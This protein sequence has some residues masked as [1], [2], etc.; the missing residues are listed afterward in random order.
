MKCRGFRPHNLAK[1][2]FHE[3]DSR[4]AFPGLNNAIMPAHH[5]LSDDLL[6]TCN[7][8]FARGVS[9]SHALAK[10][11]RVGVPALALAT[12]F[13]LASPAA[14]DEE[15]VRP[16]AALTLVD[17][18][19][20]PL[21]SIDAARRYADLEGAGFVAWHP[22][23]RAMLVT[24]RSGDTHQLHLLTAPEAVPR[25]LTDFADPVRVAQFEPREGRYIV[26]SRDHGG[27]EAH[28][29]YRLD[30]EG[31]QA[32]TPLSEPDRKADQLTFAPDG[33]HI[34]FITSSL[35]RTA[36]P[37]RESDGDRGTASDRAAR[38]VDKVAITEIHFMSPLD[39]QSDKVL[40]KLTGRRVT[41]LRFVAGGDMLE[42][43][44]ARSRGNVTWQL[45]LA[46]QR[47]GPE[48]RGVPNNEPLTEDDEAVAET[49]RGKRW[50]IETDGEFRRLTLRE[51]DSARRR[52]FM[53]NDDWDA[54][55]VAV[56]PRAG[57]PLAVT[58]NEAGY[59]V[60]KWFD[61]K[62]ERELGDRKIGLDPGVIGALRWHRRLPELAIGFS[63]ARTPGEIYSYDFDSGKLTRWTRSSDTSDAGT[64]AFVR[65]RLV[66][67]PSFDKREI[68]GFYYPAPAR[69]AGK[70]PVLITL[71]GG[72]ASQ[73]RPGFLG[74]NNYFLNELGVA[75]LYPNFRGSTGFGRRFADLDNG[76]GREGAAQDIG[77]L[78]D[79]IARQ[80]DLDAERVIVTGGSYGG[81][82]TFAVSTLYADRIAG[83]IARVGISHFVSFLNNTESYRRD[84]RRL[85]YGDERDEKMRAFL[86][87][88]SPLTNAAKITKPIMI[89]QGR[90]DPRVPQTEAVQ[91]AER[92]RANG[93]P[94]WFVMGENE[95]HGFSHKENNDYLF[96]A[97][98][99]FVK[100]LIAPRA[101]PASAPSAQSAR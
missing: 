49:A 72:P 17:V 66:R 85:E 36:A 76:F 24:L 35:D 55:R 50:T 70:R 83:S 10:A 94:V 38:P 99:E 25:K 28:R 54:E 58:V 5:F 42:V 8:S 53:T 33:K 32:I 61:P 91:M 23:Q 43:T 30:L 96:Y 18:P 37:D 75:L 31:A 34:A 29:L 101:A 74:R 98:A 90:N 69:F 22:R 21:K 78:L 67:W 93:Q 39:P 46:G 87:R 6:E 51:E 14:A 41:A 60:L 9:L 3:H 77:A 82:L 65:P 13:L 11:W 88:I 92:V 2:R 12:A 15:L 19:P 68:T 97:T 79:W 26:F 44:E 62:A 7:A 86:E 16:P 95:G 45:D 47:R 63:S 57:L 20:I 4:S 84:N 64:D 71:H 1:V 73:S 89:V 40:S 81:Y 48:S 59:S 56:P 80:P 27:D 100:R 52:Q